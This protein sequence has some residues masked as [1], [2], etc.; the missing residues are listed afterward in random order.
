MKQRLSNF[1][2]LLPSYYLRRI[3]PAKKRYFDL[4]LG[5]FLVIAVPLSS[6]ISNLQTLL[7]VDT[8]GIIT[9]NI[10]TY[11]ANKEIQ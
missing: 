8:T 6:D 2:Y 5:A 7:T 4:V 1:K 3:P 11:Y 9:Y 10:Y